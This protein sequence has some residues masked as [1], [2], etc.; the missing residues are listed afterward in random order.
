MTGIVVHIHPSIPLVM[1][2]LSQLLSMLAFLRH[3]NYHLLPE[4]Q[5]SP[6]PL[7]VSHHLAPV[8]TYWLFP[9]KEMDGPEMLTKLSKVNFVMSIVK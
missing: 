6:A 5:L 9:Y 8:L 7:V 3:L 4:L 2:F 1:Y